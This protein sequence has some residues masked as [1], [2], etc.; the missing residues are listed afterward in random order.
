M[1][2]LAVFQDRFFGA[3]HRDG[4]LAGYGDAEML[5]IG[6]GVHRNTV[7][8]ALI[9]ALRANYPTVE[10]LVGAEWFNASANEFLAENLPSETSLVSFGADYPDFLAGLPAAAELEY[11]PGVARLDR[12]WTEA[13]I[14]AD[15]G[16]LSPRALA[17]ASS[18][19]LFDL[20]LS[21]HP[22]LRLGWFETPA[23]T[24]WRQNRPPAPPPEPVDLD[25]VAEGALIARPRGE[26]VM[27]PLDAAGFAFIEK[28]V[29]GVTLGLAATAA[30]EIN[31]A[32]DLK[33]SIAQFIAVG[34]FMPIA[35]PSSDQGENHE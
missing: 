15:A 34:A 13:H 19:D 8:K 3:L 14:A 5:R 21:P 28:C 23:P 4:E 30:L 20:Q 2:D 27:L 29:S 11:L 7:Y 24:I 1:S 12:Y 6:L 31:P 16:V 33:A 25:W 22:S 9:D 17:D 10:R 35:V 32:A 18:R 26:V